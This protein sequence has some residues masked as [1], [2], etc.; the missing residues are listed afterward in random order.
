VFLGHGAGADGEVAAM[1]I[2]T[3]A[4]ELTFAG[5]PSVGT[6]WFLA[7]RGVP[8]RTLRVPAG[9]VEVRVDGD[10][11]WISARP[12][13][14]PDFNWST[15]DTAAELAALDPGSFT[16]GQHYVYVWLDEAAGTVASRMFAPAMGIAEDQATGAAAIRLTQRLDRDLTIVQGDGSRLHTHRRPDGRVEVGG[17]TRFDR[18]LTI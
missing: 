7:R 5:H 13:W 10:L 6:A 18:S 3:P 17:R 8:V 14:A 16:D 15:V 11:T 4:A 2:F 12:D 1:R 9:E